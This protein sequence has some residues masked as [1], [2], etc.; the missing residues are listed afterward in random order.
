MGVFAGAEKSSIIYGWNLI[1][2]WGRVSVG[3]ASIQV[4]STVA[5]KGKSPN[6]E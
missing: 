1:R 4:D 5:D 2:D 6:T 3:G